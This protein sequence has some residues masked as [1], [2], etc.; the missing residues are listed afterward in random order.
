MADATRPLPSLDEPDGRAFWQ[1]TKNHE[2]RYQVCDDCDGIVFFPRR[3]CTH[4][5]GMNL[6]WETSKG[7]GVIYSYS[8]VRASRHPAFAEKAP[9]AVAII[10]LDEGFRMFSNIVGVENALTDIEIGQR[11]SVEWEDHEELSLPL[12]RPAS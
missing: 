2:L 9:Y 12:F 7:E 8:V 1:A 5:V 10:D 3:H 11:V 4:C 6:R